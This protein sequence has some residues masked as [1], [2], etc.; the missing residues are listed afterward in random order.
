MKKLENINLSALSHE[1]EEEI[2]ALRQK[3]KKTL[4]NIYTVNECKKILKQVLTVN[5][6][7]DVFSFRKDRYNWLR[8]VQTHP[9]ATGSE[10][11]LL[12]FDS[13]FG[14]DDI[15]RNQMAGIWKKLLN[16]MQ[17]YEIDQKNFALLWRQLGILEAST[18]EFKF[19]VEH[20]QNSTKIAEKLGDNIIIGD[21]YFEVGLILRN[22]GEY[23]Q[24]W[25]S[26]INAEKSVQGMNHYK[27][28]VYSQG[29]RA[30]LLAIGG[31]FDD[32][33]DLLKQSLSLWEKFDAIEDKNMRHTTLHT[34]G[35]IYLQIGRVKDAKE[36][37]L[38]S[39]KLKDASGERYDST[40]RTR[41]LLADV[42]IAMGNYSEA[43]EYISEESIETSIR[44]GS[45]LYAA[46][47]L[48]TLSRVHYFENNYIQSE[49]LAKRSLEISQIANNPLTQIDTIIWV[50]QLSFLQKKF[51]VLLSI[52][53]PLIKAIN[54]LKLTPVQFYNL[55][56]QRQATLKK[57]IAFQ[58]NN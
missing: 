3:H 42:C 6:V 47:S 20:F 31:R 41:S 44:I 10:I 53:V 17:A 57:S 39:L 50:M 30:N 33:I 54:S 52:L 8:A 2:I 45:Y 35:R 14:D 5:L 51:F 55:F 32:A 22:Q 48:R 15:E 29:Q 28:I 13:Y 43:K 34:L 11:A 27:T 19:A 18:G 40:M 36:A 56:I 21:N 49:R 23:T 25:E 1:E 16:K 37:V 9:V 58:K 38:E 4:S 7:K 46:E 24:A 12:L 26:F